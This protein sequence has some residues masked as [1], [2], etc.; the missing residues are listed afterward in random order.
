[1]SVYLRAALALTCSLLAVQ[2]ATAA[3][4]TTKTLP[5]WMLGEWVVTHVYQAKSIDRTDFNPKQYYP[6]K[7]LIVAP[8]QMRLGD[9]GCEVESVIHSTGRFKKVFTDGVSGP[10]FTDYDGLPKF[11]EKVTY[12]KVQCSHRLVI[13]K[14]DDSQS[15]SRE[16]IE[17]SIPVK[18]NIIVHSHAEIDLPYYGATYLQLRK[19]TPATS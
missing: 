4:A 6:G 19:V 5:E 2:S 12:E 17:K 15:V 7:H 3:P 13:F 10:P 18:W 1:M 14:D 8:G 11:P 9:F 16:H